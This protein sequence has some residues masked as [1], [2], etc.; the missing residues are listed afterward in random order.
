MDSNEVRHRGTGGEKK[1]HIAINE[2]IAW[3]CN[4]NT[5]FQSSWQALPQPIKI[6][7]LI[8]LQ[9]QC[10]RDAAIILLIARSFKFIKTK[11]KH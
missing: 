3:L 7:F 8:Q 1:P 5:G 4:L 10:A 9:K 6:F 11:G 2:L